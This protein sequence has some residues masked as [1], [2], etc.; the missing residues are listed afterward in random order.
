V[1]IHRYIGDEYEEVLGT[2]YKTQNGAW[3]W[4]RKYVDATEGEQTVDFLE[5]ETDDIGYPH[6]W[7]DAGVAVSD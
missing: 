7:L 2:L 5:E 1:V 3:F 6:S 4:T